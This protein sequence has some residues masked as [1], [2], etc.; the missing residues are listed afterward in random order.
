ESLVQLAISLAFA[1]FCWGCVTGRHRV[2]VDGATR[3]ITWTTSVFGVRW[4][5]ERWE[6]PDIEAVGSEETRAAHTWGRLWNI[7]VVGPRGRRPLQEMAG[8][9]GDGPS[10]ARA[11]GVP[12]H[13]GRTRSVDKPAQPTKPV[14]T[15]GLFGTLLAI[16]VGVPGFF[17][18]MFGESSLGY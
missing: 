1:L 2:A 10:W 3:S 4:R 6:G 12:Y 8:S 14:T 17:W 5:T 7:Y 9:D 13:D 18:L 16:A 11:L 15:L